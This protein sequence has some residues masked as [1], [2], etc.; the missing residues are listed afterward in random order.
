MAYSI[1]ETQY[2]T[3]LSRL[4]ALE[5]HVNDLTVAQT[6]LVSLQQVNGISV[7]LQTAIA[8]IETT[9]NALETR[10]ST[11]EEEPLT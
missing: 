6:N 4:T 11:I 9:V 5:H 1:T 7:I 10:V 3:L 8:N 2:L